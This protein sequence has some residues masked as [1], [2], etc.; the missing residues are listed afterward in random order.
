[1]PALAGRAG[2]HVL[3]VEL[4][5]R[6]VCEADADGGQGFRVIRLHDI[7]QEPHPKL[8]GGAGGEGAIAGVSMAT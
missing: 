5:F 1:M 3:A 6:Q 7:A 2:F 8:L 4:A